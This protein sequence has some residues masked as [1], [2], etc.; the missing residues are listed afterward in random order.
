MIQKK[1]GD[2]LKKCGLPK[3]NANNLKEIRMI[4]KKRTG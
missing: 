4:L 1:Q 2:S 3:R